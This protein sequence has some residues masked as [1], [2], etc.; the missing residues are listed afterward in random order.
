MATLGV[1]AAQFGGT[2][3]ALQCLAC[4]LLRRFRCHHWPYLSCLLF[5]I[6]IADSLSEAFGCGSEF[7][8]IDAVCDPGCKL[9]HGDDR[10]ESPCAFIPHL[11]A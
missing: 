8:T 11:P 3:F 2:P 7:K 5:A 4:T 9:H 1:P 10:K 6:L